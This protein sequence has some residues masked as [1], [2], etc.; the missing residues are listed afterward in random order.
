MRS[1]IEV[2]GKERNEW[3]SEHMIIW[4]FIIQTW[5]DRLHKV[6]HIHSYTVR[7]VYLYASRIYLALTLL[8]VLPNLVRLV[9]E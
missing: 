3:Q 7:N 2:T 5:P 4:A 6:S 1:I 9:L 8:N